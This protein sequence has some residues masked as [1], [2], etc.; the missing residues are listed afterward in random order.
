MVVKQSDPKPSRQLELKSVLLELIDPP[1]CARPLDQEHVVRL[2][3]SID[4]FGL[5][6]RPGVIPEGDR[7]RTVYGNSRIHAYLFLGRLEIEVAVLP[8][9]TT[10][11]DEMAFSIQENMLR[12]DEHFLDLLVRI[13]QHAQFAGCSPTQAAE[14]NGVGK[15][16]LSKIRTLDSEL[17]D[18]I[19]SLAR[20]H[21]VGIS[22]L[23]EICKAKE[24]ARRLE[25]LNAYVE[26][27]LTRDQIAVAVRA[28]KAN[29]QSHLKFELQLD[30]SEVGLTLP[31]D[32]DYE[33]LAKLLKAAALKFQ[34][35]QKQDIA[36]ECLPD[37]FAKQK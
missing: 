11:A 26:G 9:G 32:C 37:I 21:G 35:Y 16:Q 10:R 31:Q 34:Q 3:R 33:R 23:Y 6:Q 4:Q 14:L 22:V 19:K 36:I 18:S 29:T 28:P 13:D 8:A 27:K 24:S 2:A 5:F 15:T 30:G 17:D 25:Y 20:E 12:K 1:T 7:F